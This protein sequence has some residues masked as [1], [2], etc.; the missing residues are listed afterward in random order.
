[1][2][3]DDLPVI[4]M[5]D[6]EASAAAERYRRVRRRTEALAAPLSPE[7]Q[8]AQS[9]PDASPTKWHR[10]HTTWFFETFLLVPF[11]PGY[12]VHDRDYGYLFNSY[13]EAVGPRQPRPERGLLTRP[14]TPAIGAY[15]AHVDAAM[16]RLLVGPLTAE[17]SE[18]L[19][20]GLAHEEQHQEL[21][22]MDILHLFAQSPL[23]PAY[24]SAAAGRAD[25]GAQRFHRFEGGVVEIGAEKAGFAF[26]NERPRHRVY[27][28]PFRLSDRLVTN[29]EWIAFID[30]GG[31]QRVDL[32]LSEGWTRARE[33]GWT[34]PAYWRREEDRTWTA[35]SLQGRRPVDPNAPVVH[36]SYYEAAAFAAWAGRRLP[37]E[38]EWEVAATAPGG[39]A[40]R[41]LYGAAW[42]WTSSA[43][44]PYPGFKPGPGAL[45]E[46]NGKF[47]VNQMVLRGGCQ[48][49]PPGHSR[50]TYRNFFHPDRR[51]MFAGVRLADD[52][53][54]DEATPAS[55]FL[56]EVVAGLSAT[57]KTLPAKYFYDAEGSRLFEQ[58]CALPEYYLT[59]TETALLREIAPEIAACIPG[60]AALVEFGS[61][62]STKTRILLDAA[63]QVSVYAPI[64]ISPTALDAAAASLRADYPNLTV[65]PLV[66]DFT[67]ALSAP[68]GARGRPIVGFFPG[69]TIG[70]FSPDEAEVL[71]RQA[72]EWLGEGAI[73]VIGADVAKDPGVLIPA[74]DD[75]RGVTAAFN[76]NILVHINRELGGSFDPEAFAHRAVWNAEESRIEMHL[77]SVRD[78]IVMVGD[79]GVRFAKGETIHTENS[80]KYRPEA[81]EAIA[82]RAGWTVARRWVS[83]DPAFAVYMLAA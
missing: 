8:A 3:P 13:Y 53:G 9:M 43:Y 61:G 72:R 35:M 39:M 7:D 33:E 64:D 83:P 22:L 47:M 34:A 5:A 56:D 58:I 23:S 18:R 12:A 4:D 60:D 70:N 21:I 69:S 27:V 24:Q 32:W 19:E 6:V 42:Q 57:P 29:G 55:S 37:T 59:R 76:R 31:Y 40:P 45:G 62:A 17:I 2:T 80:Y 10:A 51:W 63:P 73:F 25:P 75:A 79:R 65:A 14:S 68:E 67:K 15:R 50:A 36:V 49:T 66:G 20:L 38:A 48:A 82:G 54:L 16:E 81:F 52:D 30:A 11:L 77:E 26:D 71:L 28:A 74:Y 78:K 1:M 41:Q 46:Y 44:A